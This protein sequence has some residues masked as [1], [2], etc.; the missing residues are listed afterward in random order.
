MGKLGDVNGV[1]RAVG[2][3]YELMS[4][5]DVPGGV[6]S[7]ISFEC[8]SA[9]QVASN[10]ATAYVSLSI[11]E[12]AQH[13]AGEALPEISRSSSPWSRSLVLIDLAVSQVRA[14][15]ADL[16]YAARLV[17]DALT[18]SAGRPVISIQHRTL[19]FVTDV[20]GR[21]GDVPQARAVLESISATR[22]IRPQGG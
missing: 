8:Y 2:E 20:T 18:I 17:E 5:N 10:A 1:D 12:K 15:D 16:E 19:D 22:E 21:W 6:P 4:L 14:E 9:A 13:Y 3:A 11:P 7:S